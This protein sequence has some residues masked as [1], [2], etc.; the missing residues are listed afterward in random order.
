MEQAQDR[1]PQHGCGLHWVTPCL[2]TAREA[3]PVLVNSIVWMSFLTGE[4][5]SI[6]STYMETLLTFCLQG[7]IHNPFYL[8]E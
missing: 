6:V 3:A 7:P 5:L 1:H 8:L 2:G 4:N